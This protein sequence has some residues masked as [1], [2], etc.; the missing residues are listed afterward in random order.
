MSQLLNLSRQREQ[1]IIFV[2][3]EARQVDRNIASS[4]N[5]LV[6]KDVGMLQLEFDRPELN[7]LATQARESFANLK[8]DK[9]RWSYVHAPDSD[10]SGLMEN[11]LPSFWKP[12]LSNLFA[13]DSSPSPTRAP[14]HMTREEKAKKARELR[15][16]GASYGEICHAVGVKSRSTVQNYIKGY[17]NQR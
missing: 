14:K 16:G 10:F 17:P 2:T 13:A 8:G 12:R 5:V 1:T 4:S 15:A 6:F 11:E 9:R 3:Q 7:K